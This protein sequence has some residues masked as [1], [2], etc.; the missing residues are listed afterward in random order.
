MLYSAVLYL[1]H[2]PAMVKAFIQLG[3]P[4]YF[5]N[6]LGVAKILGVVALL[7]PGLCLV[8]EWAYAGFAITFIGAFISHL[9]TGETTMAIAPVIALALL[10]VSYLTRPLGRRIPVTPIERRTSSERSSG[11]FGSAAPIKN[12][13]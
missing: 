9:A 6:I 12:P 13:A 4:P 7:A 11:T 2:A 5:P 10:V 3:Y 1:T 8:K